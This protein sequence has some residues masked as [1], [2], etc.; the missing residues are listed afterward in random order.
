[1]H[2]SLEKIKAKHQDALL[3]LKAIDQF[4]HTRFLEQKAM[5]EDS[6][7]EVEDTPLKGRTTPSGLKPPQNMPANKPS[8]SEEPTD[9]N[10]PPMI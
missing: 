4:N 2:S 5:A 3:E 8:Q 1:M 9:F 10:P 7:Q 6:K